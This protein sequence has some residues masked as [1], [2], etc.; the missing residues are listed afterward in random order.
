M[1]TIN[2]NIKKQYSHITHSKKAI[3]K[4]DIKI[5]NDF[6]KMIKHFH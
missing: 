3:N 6:F 2:I 5:T 1:Q 4:L